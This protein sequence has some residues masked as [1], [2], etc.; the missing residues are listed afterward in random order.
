MAKQRGISSRRTT[1]PLVSNL[2]DTA[3]QTIPNA[4]ITKVETNVTIC[5]DT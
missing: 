2:N 1:Q 5:I 3:G 4:V